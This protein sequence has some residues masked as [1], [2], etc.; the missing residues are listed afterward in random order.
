MAIA[1][2]GFELWVCDSNGVNITHLRNIE[3][4]IVSVT[5]GS[6]SSLNNQSLQNAINAID[7]I[8]PER[9]RIA[10]YCNA[11]TYSKLNIMRNLLPLVVGNEESELSQYSGNKLKIYNPSTGYYAISGTTLTS[12]GYTSQGNWNL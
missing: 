9:E 2:K 5:T 1:Y 10:C 7:N 3:L 11:E 8:T 12:G 4:S 6:Q